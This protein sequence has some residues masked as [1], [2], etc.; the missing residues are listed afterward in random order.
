MLGLIDQISEHILSGRYYQALKLSRKLID[1][2]QEIAA[3]MARNRAALDIQYH[4]R[5]AC[6]GVNPV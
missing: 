4:Q 2:E 5:Y 6:P 3:Y 1:Y